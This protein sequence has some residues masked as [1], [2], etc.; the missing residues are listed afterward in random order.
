MRKTILITTT[1]VV[2]AILVQP[3]ACTT[4]GEEQ[5]DVSQ[6]E[7]RVNAPEF[8][9]GLEWLNTGRRLTLKELRGKIVMLDFWTYCCINCMHVIPDLKRLEEKY[10]DEL[11]VI[12]VHSAKFSG[13]QESG[14]IRQAILRYEIEHPVINDNRM[15][16]WRSFG[17]RAWPT[18][19]LI[20]PDGKV[21]GQR[22]GEGVFEVF[23]P[24]IAGMIEHFDSKGKIDRKPL[25]IVRER[26]GVAESLFSFPGKVLADA[27]G[28]R[29]FVSDSNH[30]R[31]VVL[32]LEDYSVLEIIGGG[33]VGFKD[34]SFETALLN[35]PQ[36][37]AVDG[38]K[39]Y[40]ADTENHAV[41]LADLSARTLATLAGTGSQARAFNVGGAGKDTALNSPWDLELQ[42]GALFIAM[43]GSHQIWRLDLSS[44][45]LQPHAGSGRE[46]RVDAALKQAALAQPSGLA[47]NGSVLYFADS[48]I[49]SIR[50]A[51][52]DAS[53]GV[54]TIAGGDLFE[55]GDVDAKG[56][57][58]R[59]QHPLGV[60]YRDSVLY[61]ADTYNNKIRRIRLA[62]KSVE[63][64]LGSGKEGMDDGR[65]KRASFDEPGGLSI[66]GN[67]LFIA[68]TNNHLIRVADLN[69][70]EVETVAV[71]GIEKLR[72]SSAEE[73]GPPAMELAAVEISPGTNSLRIGLVMPPDFKLNEDAPSK[74]EIELI[75]AVA[76][77][78]GFEAKLRGTSFPAEVPV[79]AS[80]GSGTVGIHF[81]LY[82]CRE[83]E[84]KLCFI[85]EGRYSLPVNVV[86]GG[87]D[88]LE[89]K[90]EITK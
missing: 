74:I 65:G 44:G 3:A 87:R 33:E 59:F 27:A 15:E 88:R 10:A 86:E 77:G 69:T 2:A 67:R 80:E 20:D 85:K 83:G 72:G 50:E 11:V 73:A 4:S 1:F 48:E 54:R 26:E 8:P 76:P 34:G 45:E 21:V 41:R 13:E 63:S 81:V 7:G 14:N 28:G 64:W 84:E 89:V 66:A 57:R 75:G 82:Y 19:V 17:V 79:T 30:N 38:D 51:D 53:G 6:F 37:M 12:G 68:D 24:F 23:D 16:I 90:L 9:G 61:V 36:G 49:S 62:D 70:G 40:L 29:L 5:T 47:S 46:A 60:E 78:E 42:R 43:A 52:I 32:S 55:F 22:S 71:K 25:E 39:L 18:I 35:H 58:A 31:I 56:D